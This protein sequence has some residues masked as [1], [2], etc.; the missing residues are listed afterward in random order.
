MVVCCE[1]LATSLMAYRAALECKTR[2]AVKGVFAT[3]PQELQLLMRRA[4]SPGMTNQL[5][6]EESREKLVKAM[7][8]AILDGSARQYQ[9][10]P[11]RNVLV[12]N[13]F[14]YNQCKEKVGNHV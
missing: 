13:A 9:H 3:L 7:M 1:E 2:E 12:L 8:V 6:D 4:R 14:D 5:F 10:R 11:R